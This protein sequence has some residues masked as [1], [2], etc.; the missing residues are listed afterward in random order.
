VRSANLPLVTIGLPVRNA[1]RYLARALEDLTRQQYSNI[2][3]LIS[4]N[5]STDGTF[6][7]C[8]RYAADPRVRL[9]RNPENIG[10]YGNFKRVLAEARGEFFMWAASDDRWA[11]EFVGGLLSELQANPSASLAVCAIERRRENG[12]LHDLMRYVGALDPTR[13]SPIRLVDLAA[14]GTEYMLFIYGLFRTE[15]L[16]RAFL[17]LPHFEAG[18]Q[19]FFI[20]V[21]LS[22][23]IRYVDQVWSFRRVADHPLRL[24][25]ADDPDARIWRDPLGP[26]R[27]F[28]QAGPY[29]LRSDLVPTRY[30]LL[31]PWV[32]LRL[33]TP[34]RLY[35]G[36]YVLST[37]LGVKLLGADRLMAIRKVLRRALIH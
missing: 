13:A 32:V 35:F 9:W 3:I 21:A 6:E 1:E 2:E 8:Q 24:R 22:T 14:A 17:R 31:V 36:A 20:H 15:Y 25:Y 4:D 33:M 10:A 5:A 23:R 16:R 18:D 37:W 26:W 11:P 34:R 27:I 7:I 19:L 12:S 29:L 28:M 30:K